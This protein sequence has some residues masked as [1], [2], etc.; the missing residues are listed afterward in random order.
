MVAFLGRRLAKLNALLRRDRGDVTQPL[1]GLGDKLAQGRRA[2]GGGLVDL[3][4]AVA[5]VVNDLGEMGPLGLGLGGEGLVFGPKAVSDADQRGALPGQAFLGHADLVADAQPG[6]FQPRDLAG[7]V[8]AGDTGGVRCLAGGGGQVGGPCGQRGLGLADLGLGQVGGLG[9]HLGVAGD[10]VGDADRLGVQGAGQGAHL[11]ALGAQAAGQDVGGAHRGLGGVDQ[12]PALGGQHVAQR[13]EFVARLA[14]GHGGLFDLAS[15]GLDRRACAARGQGGRLQQGVGEDLGAA[16]LSRQARTLVGDI[17]RQPNQGHRADSQQAKDG[18]GER[19][20]G[21]GD[22]LTP[23]APGEHDRRQGPEQRDQA[24][25]QKEGPG[26]RGAHP[27]DARLLAQ[28]RQVGRGLS[29]RGGPLGRGHDRAGLV[30]QAELARLEIKVFGR[31]DQAASRRR[32]RG[33]HARK[34]ERCWPFRSHTRP[35]PITRRRDDRARRPRLASGSDLAGKRRCA[36]PVSR[37]APADQGPS[38]RPWAPRA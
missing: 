12:G 6:G 24:R 4:C 21:K 26:A 15:D 36:K 29:R 16:G 8:L 5:R 22:D 13:Q 23:I 38:P 1:A 10:G 7:E 31:V 32:R 37:S 3:A 14:G 18:Q 2:A 35:C 20:A 33:G 27:R 28:R 25:R 17:G 9:H 19:V 34:I 11:L 30:G